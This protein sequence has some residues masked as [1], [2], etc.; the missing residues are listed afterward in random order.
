MLK[1]ALIIEES[2]IITKVIEDRLTRNGFRSFAYAWT[3]EDALEA[4][5]R[6]PPD[7]V[8]I[9]DNIANGSGITAAFKIAERYGSPALLVTGDAQRARLNLPDGAS[10]GGPFLLPE[11]REALACAAAPSPVALVN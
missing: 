10:V 5:D 2:I 7:L 11:I 3:E 8:L 6:H 1:H 9:G 4:A